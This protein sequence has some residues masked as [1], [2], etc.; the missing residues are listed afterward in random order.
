M[1]VSDIVSG[2]LEYRARTPRILKQLGVPVWREWF[3]RADEDEYQESLA[4]AA[5]ALSPLSPDLSSIAELSK[6]S[7]AHLHGIKGEL[8]DARQKE[9][10][11]RAKHAVIEGKGKESAIG[12]DGLKSGVWNAED[13]AELEALKNIDFEHWRPREIRS[14]LPTLV[15]PSLRRRGSVHQTSAT[16]TALANLGVSV[17]STSNEPSLDTITDADRRDVSTSGLFGQAL[18]DMVRDRFHVEGEL[19]DVALDDGN[20]RPIV[21]PVTGKV[22]RERIVGIGPSAPPVSPGTAASKGAGSERKPSKLKRA[23]ARK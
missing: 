5:A 7:H 2:H 20:R 9:V 23:S 19:D 11:E 14:T 1:D 13:I 6:A 15:L 8:E 22:T 10:V 18:N 3:D 16:G 21:D 17:K 4:E 12:A